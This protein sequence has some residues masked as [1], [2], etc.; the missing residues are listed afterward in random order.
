MADKDDTHVEKSHS[1]GYQK[2]SLKPRDFS[3]EEK[4]EHARMPQYFKADV[5]HKS[6]VQKERCKLPVRVLA[7]GDSLTAGYHP[8]GQRSRFKPYGKFLAEHLAPHFDAEVWVCGLSGLSARQM[9]EKQANPD[10]TDTTSRR[11]KGLKQ[12]MK[13]CGPFDLVLLMAGTNDL[14]GSTPPKCIVEQIKQLHKICHDA[15]TPTFVMS[16]P[17]NGRVSELEDE[18]YIMAWRSVNADLRKWASSSEAVARVTKYVDVGELVPWSAQSAADGGLF[19]D[20]DL[21]HFSPVGSET[22]GI[23]LADAVCRYFDSNP[24]QE[25]HVEDAW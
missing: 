12:A 22:L 2:L 16:V 23:S 24:P 9:V 21:I 19:C 4:R 3:D 17:D 11:G 13:D 15:G 8:V 1:G 5:P 18:D 25:V 20:A 7:Y 14:G 10:I 6:E